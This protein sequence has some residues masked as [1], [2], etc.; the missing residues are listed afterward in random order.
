MSI[1][2]GTLGTQDFF[3]VTHLK[4]GYGGVSYFLKISPLKPSRKVA[5]RLADLRPESAPAF[6]LVELLV[7]IAIIAILAALALAAG[8]GAMRSSA[9]AKALSN[10]KQ[11]GVIL[12]NYA[13]DNNNHLPLSSGDWANGE[14]SWFQ[15]ILANYAGLKLDWGKPYFLPD[16]FYDPSVGKGRQHPFGSFGINT[17]IVLDRLSCR[18]RFGH[19]KGISLLSIPSPSRKV[20]YC[21]AKENGWDSTWYLDGNSFAQNGLD[22]KSG[23]DPRNGGGAAALFADGH[24]EKLDVKNMDQATRRQ[25]F[26]LGP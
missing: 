1:D 7:V 12:A 17:S 15:P 2:D 23:P 11:T 26:M 8:Q 13:A 18:S 20:I 16:I 9:A 14:I 5:L 22:E 4:A 24:V 19:T 6:T 10:V 25:L 3:P 21:S